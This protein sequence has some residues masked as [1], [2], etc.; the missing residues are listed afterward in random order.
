M[1]RWISK[2]KQ[3]PKLKGIDTD[4]CKDAMEAKQIIDHFN[5]AMEEHVEELQEFSL[6][7][8]SPSERNRAKMKNMIALV[9]K[10]WRKE[11][12]RWNVRLMELQQISSL[13][14]DDSDSSS[15]LPVSNSS[16]IC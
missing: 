9:E 11:I 5:D 6:I 14:C 13:A 8:P 2:Y 1:F 10:P 3:F 12:Q 15:K 4:T 7:F 16:L